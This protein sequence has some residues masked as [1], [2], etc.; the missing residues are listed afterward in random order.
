MDDVR[1]AR[2]FLKLALLAA[3]LA[4][5]FVMARFTAAGAFLTP[6]GIGRG[7]E[8]LRGSPW[9]PVAFVTIYAGATALAVPGT[10]LTLAGGALFGLFWGTILNSIAANIGANIAYLLARALG[11]ESLERLLG[12]RL[13]RLDEATRSHGFRGLFMLRLVPLVPFNA[14]NFGSG[15]TAIPWPSYAL[16]TVIGIL[17]GTIVYTF[18]AD[19]LLQGSQ[20]ASREALT[21]VL[22][23]GALLIMLSVLPIVIKKMKLALRVSVILLAATGPSVASAQGIPDHAAFSALLSSVVQPPRVHY[24]QLRRERSALDAYIDQLSGTDPRELEAAS[25]TVRLAFWINAYN[26]CML[27]RVV[28]HYPIE[29][30]A[31]LLGSLRNTLA[32]RPR[33]SVW[34]IEEVFTDPHCPVAGS[35]RSQDEIE[36]E[37]IR[38]MGDPRIHFVVNCAARSCPPLAPTAFAAERLDEMLDGAVR[39]FVSDPAHFLIEQGSEPAIRVN[40]IL[41]WYGEDFGGEDGIREFLARYLSGEPR[42]L[43][44]RADTRVHFFDYDWTLNDIQH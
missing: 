40:R 19:A 38:P 42:S 33:N 21:R 17:P 27:K 3:L 43:A 23:A 44:L 9:A 11:R 14:L 26:A 28:D 31:S 20:E 18:F 16:A 10:I 39:S 6:D 7:I 32:G 35:L 25:H 8:L 5:G 4:G 12:N 36:H 37:I 24:D 15:L 34:Q 1:G 29:P 22:L 2:P 41:D 30:N 13:A